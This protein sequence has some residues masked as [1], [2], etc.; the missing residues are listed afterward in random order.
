MSWFK[1][2]ENK[3]IIKILDVILKKGSYKNSEPYYLNNISA[4]SPLKGNKGHKFM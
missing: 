2:F 1:L 3:T 4:R